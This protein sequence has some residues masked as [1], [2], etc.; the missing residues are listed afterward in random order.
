[1][2][3]HLEPALEP[4]VEDAVGD[5][6]RRVG[7]VD[8]VPERVELEDAADQLGVDLAAE[9][10]ALHLNAEP[11]DVDDRELAAEQLP[12]VDLHP[13][14]RARE[15]EPRDALDV[16]DAGREREDE[17][18]RAMLDVRPLDADL[19]DLDREPARPL[20]AVAARGADAEEDAEPGPRVERAGAVELEVA[21]LA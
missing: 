1:D 11:R 2:A 10:V 6:R 8:H 4:R 16:V 5:R 7:D 3:G 14:D 13:V 20:E 17:V 18:G 21:R 12:D 15:R 19:V 9:Q